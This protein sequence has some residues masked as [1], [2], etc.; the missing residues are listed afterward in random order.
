MHTT[1]ISLL[2]R[3]RKPNADDA[4][5]RFVQLY[6][7]LLMHWARHVG[8]QGEEATDL[9]QEVF[10]LLVVKLPEFTYDRAGSFRAWLR[11]VALNKWRQKCRRAALPMVQQEDAIADVAQA[12]PLEA[13]WDGEYRRQLVGNALRLMQAEF[14]PSTWKA[15]WENTV[16]GK[17]A[18]E[19]AAELGLTPGAV[20][21]AKFRVL[22]RL[23]MELRGLLD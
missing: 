12:D 5:S 20:R 22:S 23:R 8:I 16:G 9:V 4:W 3:L 1:P 11:T 15:C 13:A 21:A 10:A 6:T 7:P 19:V 17:S 18:A 14:Q 2:E